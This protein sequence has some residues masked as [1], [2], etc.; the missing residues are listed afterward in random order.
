MI[1]PVSK[2]VLTVYIYKIELHY[3]TAAARMWYKV[4]QH[5]WLL[6]M[7]TCTYLSCSFSPA[8]GKCW[9][10]WY[11]TVGQLLYSRLRK[12][13]WRS[14]KLSGF[15]REHWQPI[16]LPNSHR[17]RRCG[18]TAPGSPFIQQLQCTHSKWQWGQ[19]SVGIVVG[20]TFSF[21]RHMLL[22]IS[23]IYTHLSTE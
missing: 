13:R 7:C 15:T 14:H 4:V 9:Q 12:Q 3:S 10:S 19:D 17:V 22:P 21:S 2:G 23:L 20:G 11:W 1:A 18:W 6:Y 5:A 16:L 8:S